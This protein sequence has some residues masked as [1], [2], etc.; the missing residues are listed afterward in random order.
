LHGLNLLKPSVESPEIGQPR[1]LP[2]PVRFRTVANPHWSRSWMKI[3]RPC[4]G[5]S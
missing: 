4:S 1:F 5:R 3:R 2:G